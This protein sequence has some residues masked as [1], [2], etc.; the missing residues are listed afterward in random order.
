MDPGLRRDDGLEVAKTPAS[1]RWYPVALFEKA[2]R[3]IP[4]A[5]TV[6]EADIAGV[7]MREMVENGEVR[8]RTQRLGQLDALAERDDRIVAA[9][10]QEHRTGDRPEIPAS[11]IEAP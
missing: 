7:D 4:Q 10:D 2:D 1:R 5:Q 3:G 6:G 8:P 9:M 11:K